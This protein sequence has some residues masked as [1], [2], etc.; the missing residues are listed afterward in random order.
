MIPR[1][2]AWENKISLTAMG[3][4]GLIGVDT[5][6]QRGLCNVPYRDDKMAI[7]MGCWSW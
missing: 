7:S 1:F 3:E 6:K 5:W 2:L 4:K